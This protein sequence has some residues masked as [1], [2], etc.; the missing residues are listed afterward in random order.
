MIF[1]IHLRRRGRDP[2]TFDLDQL[3][4]QSAG[5]SGAEIEQAIVSALHT[6]FGA[7]ATLTTEHILTALRE[8]PPLS[9]TMRERIAELRSWA[10]TRCVAA[11]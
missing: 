1:E 4:A 6:A 2:K 8:S 7:R 3:V 5:Y 10:R 11:D 9:V